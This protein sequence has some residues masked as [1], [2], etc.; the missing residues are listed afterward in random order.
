M[1]P[2]A[3]IKVL[4]NAFITN[5]EYRTEYVILILATFI[6]LTMEMAVYRQI[7][8]QRD[9]VEGLSRALALPFVL[10]GALVGYSSQLW[11]FVSECID[12]IRTGGFRKYLLQPI[13][14]PSYFVARAIGPKATTWLL[15]LAT[16]V[17]VRYF[18]AFAGL[19]PPGT[20][21]PFLGAWLASVVVVWEIYFLLVL[22]GFWLEESTFLATAFN[23][24]VGI[25]SGRILPLSW[26]SPGLREF[27]RWTPLPL[28]GDFPV[29]TA[30]GMISPQ[31]Y[32]RS[33]LMA[34]GWALAILVL[35]G[36]L[37]GKAYRRYESYGG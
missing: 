24:G 36:W 22:L 37:T 1:R 29:R 16:F 19:L 3:F 14:Y 30:L 25:F 8:A 31:E 20:R 28:L 23:I 27:L 7:Y 10:T 26:F 15:A 5:M 33:L 4:R 2:R 32:G 11:S 35:N 17:I 21:W 9:T 12:E 6:T 13:H 18:P 34:V